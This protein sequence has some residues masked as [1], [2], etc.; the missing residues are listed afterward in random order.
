[1]VVTV[2]LGVLVL[3]YSNTFL[4]S[5]KNLTSDSDSQP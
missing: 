5:V 3:V 2:I 4:L 1:M